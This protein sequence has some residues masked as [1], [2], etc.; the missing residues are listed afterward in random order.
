LD[1]F[2]SDISSDIALAKSENSGKRTK[3]SEKGGRPQ[4]LDFRSVVEDQLFFAGLPMRIR[5]LPLSPPVQILRIPK[6]SRRN[7]RET[8][9][10]HHSYS[11]D[12]FQPDFSQFR[13]NFALK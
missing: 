3:K 6:D 10:L 11:H 2:A 4:T 8:I 5:G 7:R 1:A 12:V 9:S 13:R